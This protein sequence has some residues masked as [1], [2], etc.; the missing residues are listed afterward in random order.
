[1][2]QQAVGRPGNLEEVVDALR[3]L[4]LA[5][6]DAGHPMAAAMIAGT[7]DRLEIDLVRQVARAG[8]LHMAGGRE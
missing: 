5:T 1:M 8:G 2:A 3:R 4:A 7:A 6:L